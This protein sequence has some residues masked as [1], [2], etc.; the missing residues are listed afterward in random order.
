[1]AAAGVPREEIFVTTKLSPRELRADE[2]RAQVETSLEQLG[3][4]HVDLLLIH[5]PNPDVPLEE[6]LGAMSAVR[7]EGLSRHLGV[8]NFPPPLLREALELAPVIADQVKYHPY[9][10]QPELLELA[11]ER[12]VMITAYSPFARGEALDDP[13]L[14]E[15]AGAH[16]RTPAQVVLRWLLDQPLV[17]TVPK[18]SSHERR[19]ANL[20]VFGFELSEQDRARITD[21]AR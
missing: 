21:L 6:T 17:S 14:A 19:A 13:V 7:D 10:G 9:H 3:T 4:D 1:M 18:A 8:S 20:D 5:W 15:I 11:R 12:D 16:G 2:V